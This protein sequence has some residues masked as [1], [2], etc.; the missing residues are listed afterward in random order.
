MG[1]WIWDRVV[2]SR[3]L[4]RWR[5]DGLPGSTPAEFRWLGGLDAAGVL[6]LRVGLNL[7]LGYLFAPAVVQ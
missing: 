7:L 6:P 3:I 5:E 4:Q 2:A 1:V